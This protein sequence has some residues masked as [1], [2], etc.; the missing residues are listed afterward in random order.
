MFLK[1]KTHLQVNLDLFSAQEKIY[2]VV[3]GNLYRSFCL[4]F[5][6]FPVLLIIFFFT[7]FSFMFC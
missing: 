1:R 3:C 4:F 5:F 7:F 6:F 2:F